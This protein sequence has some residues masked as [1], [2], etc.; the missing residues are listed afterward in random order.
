MD[1]YEIP[2]PRK[3]HKNILLLVAAAL[4]VAVLVSVIYYLTKVNKP[5]SS[6]SR[7]V[8]FTIAKGIPTRQVAEELAEEKIIGS[9]TIFLVYTTLHS[10]SGKIKAGQYALNTNMAI[11]EIVD[12]L[13]GGKVLSTARN[14]TFIE[15]WTNK[16]VA[17]YLAGR[18]IISDSAEF[19]RLL[20]QDKYNFKFNA[21]G[22][23]FDYQ[24][25]LFP[26]TYKLAADGTASQLIQKMLS[27]FENKIT[28][29]MLADI[30]KKHTD[31]KQVMI[32]SSIIEKEV[33]RN[34]ENLT[35]NDL[36]AMQRERDL[37][38]S[39]FYN[40]L[41]LD[42]PLESDATVNYFTGKS[43]RSVSIADTKIKSLYNTYQVKGLPP[44]P[45]SNPGLGAIKAAIYPA[46][47]DYLFFLN[48]PDGTAYFA[49][50]LDEH[51]ANRAKYLK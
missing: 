43:D 24:G 27:N 14:F 35:S 40:R 9:P 41:A 16:Q 46:N 17:S 11:P 49:K 37:V 47:T 50:T 15:G 1:E 30:Q 5:A 12:I 21:Q 13:T 25:F 34:K 32:L 44:T 22:K 20:K 26:D 8:A 19:D 2:H 28:D 18:Q 36:N 51:N 7:E 48:S 33:G 29:Q 31:L 4:L 45:I 10:A 23:E 39:V 6:E 3:Q 42:M 38:A